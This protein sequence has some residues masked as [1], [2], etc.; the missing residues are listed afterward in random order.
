MVMKYLQG[1]VSNRFCFK[2]VL[3]QTGFV[4][5]RFCFKQVLFQTGFVSNRFCFIVFFY[6]PQNF[7]KIK[8][9]E[10]ILEKLWGRWSSWSY[11][12]NCDR[13]KSRTRICNI[14]NIDFGGRA[15]SQGSN[16]D[17]SRCLPSCYGNLYQ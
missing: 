7:L 17:D 4:S 14:P 9:F 12:T 16:N 1:F 13:S 5:N 6:F 2:Q 10:I 11:C 3:F 15:C 8:I